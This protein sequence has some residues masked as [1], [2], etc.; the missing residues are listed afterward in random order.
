MHSGV[1]PKALLDSL[2]IPVVFDNPNVGQGLAD[3]PC[4]LTIF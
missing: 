3:Q 4:Q 1:G 2:N